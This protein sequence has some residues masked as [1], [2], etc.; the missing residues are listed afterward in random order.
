MDD[1]LKRR[2]VYHR[3]IIHVPVSSREFLMALFDDFSE[4]DRKTFS[5]PKSS[6]NLHLD[7][8]SSDQHSLSSRCPRCRVVHT[9]MSGLWKE[10]REAYAKEKTEEE[11]YRKDRE[12]PGAVIIPAKVCSDVWRTLVEYKNIP[13]AIYTDN[14]TFR[15]DCAKKGRRRCVEGHYAP[16]QGIASDCL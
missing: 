4:E 12:S 7:C 8:F 3:R 14:V 2:S 16:T 11:K 1:Y 9:D 13:G 10:D 5:N 15:G 6:S